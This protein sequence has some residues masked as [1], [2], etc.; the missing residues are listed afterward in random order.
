MPTYSNKEYLRII[1]PLPNYVKRDIYSIPII[2]PVNINISD[3]NNGKWL[4]TSQNAKL[5]DSHASSKIVHSFNYD[6]VLMRYLN[7]IDYYIY[8]TGRYLAVSSFDF[9]MDEKMDEHQIVSAVYNNRWSGAY[10][11]SNGRTVLPTIGWLRKNTYDIC[12][13]GI[14]DGGT[15]LISSLGTNNEESY[16]VFINGYYEF[17]CRFPNTRLIC[18]GDKLI[19][20]DDDVCMVKY[21]ESFGNWERTPGFWQ[22]SMINWDM[23]IKEVI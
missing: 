17:R 4:I 6:N 20:M 9:S 14:R 8:R 16:D 21:K 13:S 23:T 10:M 15:V 12:F 19:G 22:P 11:Q 1:R 7:N 18:V 3:I 5:S 2:E